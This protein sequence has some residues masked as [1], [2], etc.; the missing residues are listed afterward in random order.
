M[1]ARGGPGRACPSPCF[2]RTASVVRSGATLTRVCEDGEGRRQ[3]IRREL[4][5]QSGAH[6]RQAVEHQDDARAARATATLE[7]DRGRN[8][9]RAHAV[10]EKGLDDCRLPKLD[11]ETGR[12][13]E[14]AGDP[15]RPLSLGLPLLDDQGPGS[16]LALEIW[17]A[18]GQQRAKSP[19]FIAAIGR[20]D[21]GIL[22]GYVGPTAFGLRHFR[23]RFKKTKTTQAKRL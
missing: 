17:S 15:Y 6:R 9:G 7:A 11:P 1:R 21:S 12:W 4:H 22:R 23:P 20:P 2:A 18:R 3:A 10:V 8:L 13:G 19:Q 16:Q 5:V 14:A